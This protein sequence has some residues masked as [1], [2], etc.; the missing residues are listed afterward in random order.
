MEGRIFRLKAVAEYLL[1]GIK[2]DIFGER[3]MLQKMIYFAKFCSVDLGYR[4]SWYIHGPYSPGLTESAFNYMDSKEYYDRRGSRVKLSDSGEDKLK[5]VKEL[6][7]ERDN[8]L[9]SWSDAAWLELLASVHY[10]SKF[11]SISAHLE[12]QAML[13]K[14]R[15]YGKR[16]FEIEHVKLALDVLK[17]CHFIP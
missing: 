12:A 15:I 10:L 13:E 1:G 11:A 9:P 16:H 14:L 7:K 3:L 4:F 2:M 8:S 5:R 6:L 17:R